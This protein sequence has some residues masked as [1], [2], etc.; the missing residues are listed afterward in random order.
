MKLDKIILWQTLRFQLC[1]LLNYQRLLDSVEQI[2]AF[3]K[4]KVNFHEYKT[5]YKVENV[6]DI[7]EK[8]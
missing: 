5:N 4:N 8:S 7:D 1:L 3:L 2:S 6:L